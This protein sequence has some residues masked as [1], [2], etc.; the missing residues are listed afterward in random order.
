RCQVCY[1][2]RRYKEEARGHQKRYRTGRCDRKEDLP[3]EQTADSLNYKRQEPFGSARSARNAPQLHCSP[4]TVIFP[5]DKVFKTIMGSNKPV[6]RLNNTPYLQQQSLRVTLSIWR[7]IS[8]VGPGELIRTSSRMTA[9]EYVGIL[10]DVLLPSIEAMY[11]GLQRFT[12]VHNKRAAHKVR[13][14]TIRFR[15]RP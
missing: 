10:E 5:D 15:A 8:C 6:W 2:I 12:F 1:W 13:M 9:E 14:V 11:P 4:H 3:A 7:W